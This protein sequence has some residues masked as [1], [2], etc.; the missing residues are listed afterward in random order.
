MHVLHIS[1]DFIGTKVHVNLYKRLAGLGINQTIYC[2]IRNASFG[3]R[4]NFSAEG[5][6]IIYD[7]V[8]KSY[9]RYFYHIKRHDIF[10]S[11]QKKVNLKAID[12]CHAATLMSDGGQAYMI[13]KKY[14]I[15]Y[16]VAVRNTDI[17][18]FLNQAPNTWVAARKI[19][20][21]AQKV[22]L[23]S[24][25]LMD[26]ISNHKVIK[27]ILPEIKDKMI[28]LPNGVDDYFLDRV[29]HSPR[30]NHGN[31]VL[32]VGDF[33]HNKNVVRLSEAVFQ[34]SKE[35]GFRNIK[36]TLVGGDR[37]IPDQNVFV[38]INSHPELVDYM[39]PIYDKDKLCE[40]FRNHS[41]FAM[42]SIF[43]TFGLVFVEALSQNLP[44]IF[45]KGQAIDGMFPST[46]GIGV[47]PLS[48]EE[49]KTAIRSILID[50]EHYSNSGI[51]FEKFRWNSIAKQYIELYNGI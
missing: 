6:E 2:P 47:N 23:I 44:V 14:H 51:D 13:Y 5:T 12:L 26:A 17:N 11:L 41:V 42:P 27:P 38:W 35:D 36:L 43:E 4:N 25:A 29:N 46:S 9:H 20:L 3:G 34:L 1:S 48:V 31:S 30:N 19:L 7:Y 8:I 39:G 22:L 45:T 37:K 33:T 28:L 49:I 10:R 16:V 32:Y 24:Q 40:V 15:P 21:N 18:S 50:N